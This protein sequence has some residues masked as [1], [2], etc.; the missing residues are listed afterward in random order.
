MTDY[1]YSEDELVEAFEFEGLKHSLEQGWLD[2]DLI[3]IRRLSEAVRF[4]LKALEAYKGAMNFA[5]EVYSQT[6]DLDV[7]ED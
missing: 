7:E 6:Q 4:A 1:Y 5:Y 3:A 2:P